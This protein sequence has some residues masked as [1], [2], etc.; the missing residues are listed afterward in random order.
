MNLVDDEDIF[1]K[2]VNENT[3][4]DKVKVRR[5]VDPYYMET[6]AFD[7]KYIDPEED[8]II[9]KDSYAEEYKCIPY[10]ILL[11]Y[12][13]VID[14]LLESLD[15]FDDATVVPITISH[16]PYSN[17]TVIYKGIWSYTGYLYKQNI[18]LTEDCINVDEDDQNILPQLLG[19]VM[20]N[21]D[22]S[23][24]TLNNYNNVNEDYYPTKYV[25]R[26]C[27][28]KEWVVSDHFKDTFVLDP[29]EYY[30]LKKYNLSHSS[31]CGFYRN[32]LAGKELGFGFFDE[33]NEGC[34]FISKDSSALYVDSIGMCIIPRK[35]RNT[36]FVECT[37]DIWLSYF[38][39]SNTL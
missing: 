18:V 5:L 34:L 22:A 15:Y 31:L 27:K 21:H 39:F 3:V 14:A 35:L 17:S 4:N 38:P 37:L 2:L 7:Q 32:L 36:Y 9:F 20:Y 10:T 23:N 1:S 29:R 33:D 6:D 8:I 25:C 16:C 19:K 11:Y 24:I 13:I 12:K 30:N 28:W 26:T